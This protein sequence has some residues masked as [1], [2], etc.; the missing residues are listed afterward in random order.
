[1]SSSDLQINN[2]TS[3][4]PH[5]H[6]SWVLS[7]FGQNSQLYFNFES[8]LLFS[9][10]IYLLGVEAG[11]CLFVFKDQLSLLFGLP[12]NS[13]DKESAWNTG[14][15]S[16][17]PGSGRSPGEGNSYPLQ[18]SWASPVARMVRNPS[19]MRETWVRSLGWEDP[20]KEGMATHSVYL[21]GESPGTKQPDRLR[22]MEPQR[23]R[24]DQLSTT[25]HSL[26]HL[27]PQF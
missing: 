14:D 7:W 21:P 26:P 25:Q 8:C 3:E 11:V 6:C 1:M 13:D 23:A 17:I 2:S 24:A 12:G 22:S 18:Y 9:I 10:V 20:L 27:R 16:W 4:S 15:L 19:T 5:V